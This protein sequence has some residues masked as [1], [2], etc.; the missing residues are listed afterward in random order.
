MPEF[1]S[2]I[3]VLANN[4]KFIDEE[5]IRATRLATIAEYE[6]VQMY[7]LIGE[8]IDN[9]LA[10]RVLKSVADEKSL[11][12]GVFLRLLHE[13]APDEESTMPKA[14]ETRRRN[15]VNDSWN[16]VHSQYSENGFGILMPL[17]LNPF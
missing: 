2:P 12:M 1:G 17:K 15:Q 9:K 16:S 13:L 5:L 7:K 14:R 11:R 8:S 3:E 6:A 4:R 10:T